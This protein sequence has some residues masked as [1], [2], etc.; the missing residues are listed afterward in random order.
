MEFV[1]R[2]QRLSVT[3][4]TGK[5]GGKHEVSEK[6]LYRRRGDGEGPCEPGKVSSEVTCTFFFTCTTLPLGLQRLLMSE[7]EAEGDW[8]YCVCPSGCHLCHS[9]ESCASM[10]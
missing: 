6:G 10:K 9:G 2:S 1:S 5:D 3:V 4:G 8:V 7:L